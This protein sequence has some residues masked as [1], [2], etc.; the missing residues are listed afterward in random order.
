MPIGHLQ[1]FGPRAADKPLVIDV[2]TATTECAPPQCQGIVAASCRS[3]IQL[4]LA[5]AGYT[6]DNEAA[7]K[8]CSSTMSTPASFVKPSW[9]DSQDTRQQGAK[10]VTHRSRTP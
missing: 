3:D 10:A 9:L 4:E 7:D 8:L 5:S 1:R 2:R 6:V